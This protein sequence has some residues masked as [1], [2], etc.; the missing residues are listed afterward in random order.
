LVIT[1]G[2]PDLPVL[3]SRLDVESLEAAVE[4][5]ATR[6]GIESRN[7]R[8]SIGIWSKAQ[9]SRHDE[10]EHIGLWA[11]IVHRVRLGLD[12]VELAVGELG[13][14]L[15]RELL[16]QVDESLCRFDSLLK[17]E[18]SPELLGPWQR[19]GAIACTRTS[20]FRA[21]SS[22]GSAMSYSPK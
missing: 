2:A 9:R 1:Q 21:S 12:L 8:Y 20:D 5:H 14:K 11:G 15:L 18:V 4:V 10:V 17:V 16:E 13:E 3:W 6:E 7:V 19:L 22:N